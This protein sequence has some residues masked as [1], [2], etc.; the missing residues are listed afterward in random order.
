MATAVTAQPSSPIHSAPNPT[1]PSQSHS[2]SQSS[3][4]P[5]ASSAN[6]R[7]TVVNTYGPI[8]TTTSTNAA[9]A[10]AAAATAATPGSTSSIAGTTSGSAAGSTT[11]STCDACHRRKSRCAMNEMVNKCYSCDFHRQDCTFTL[12]DPNPSQKRKVEDSSTVDDQA[13]KRYALYFSGPR[14]SFPLLW[15]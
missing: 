12:S 10:A 5:N 4:N 9:A 14:N 7:S 8:S 2:Q 15:M 1:S 6:A 11:S 13:A 3:T